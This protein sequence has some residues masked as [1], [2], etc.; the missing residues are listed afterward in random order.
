MGTNYYAV[1]NK[2]SIRSPYHIGKSSAGWLFL[3]QTQ[4]KKWDDPPVIWNTYK[5]VFD[6]L[7]EHTVIK[8][9]FVI[10]N[11]YNELVTYDYFKKLVD[12]K[13]ADEWCRA[14][15]DNFHCA[16]NVDGCRFSDEEF[17]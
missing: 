11:E 13:Q 17:S 12:D 15:K 2:P 14:N 8:K 16:R 9:D 4:N 1:E 7:Y 6:W 3:F 10:M 5:Q